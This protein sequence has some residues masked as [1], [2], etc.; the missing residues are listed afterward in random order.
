MNEHSSPVAPHRSWFLPH[1]RHAVDKLGVAVALTFL[2]VIALFVGGR[3]EKAAEKNESQEQFRLLAQGD[4]RP[5]PKP[6][7][8]LMTAAPA[9][10][11]TGL[12]QEL[13]DPRRGK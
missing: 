3:G 8:E 9:Q 11:V 10:S 4:I 7:L 12:R 2:V 1:K 13:E 5:L 6:S